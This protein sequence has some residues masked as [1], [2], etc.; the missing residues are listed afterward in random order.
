MDFLQFNR[1]FQVLICTRC[2]YALVPGTIGSHLVSLHKNEVTKSERR[3]CA[4]TWKNKPLQPVQ[5]IQRLDL[6]VDTLPIPN[7]ALFHNGMR[8]RLCTELSYICGGGTITHMQLHLKT[9]HGWQSGYNGGRPSKEVLAS[10]LA[11]L[12]TVIITPVSYQTFHRS[13][14]TRYFQVATLLEPD[15]RAPKAN[16]LPPPATLE[17]QIELQL[18]E[19]MRVV[20]ARASTVLQ[21][22]LE[23]SAWIQTTEWIRYLQGHDIEAAARLI[24]LPHSSE[25]EPDLVAILASFDRL[26]EQARDSVLQGK[27]NAFDQQRI[28]SFLRSGSRTSKA[29]DRPLAHKLKEGTYRKYKNTWKQLLCFVFRMIYLERQPALHCLLT[30]AQSAALDGVAY[31]ARVFVQQQGLELCEYLQEPDMPTRQQK[32]D[33]A[34]LQFCIALLDHR[35]MGDIFDS[36]IVGFLAVLGIDTAR[37]GFQEATAYTPHL[38]ALI[39]ISQLLV[40]QRAVVAAEGGETEYPAQMIEV[41]QDRFMVYGSRSPIDW[42]QKLRVYGKKIRDS[43]TSLGY[44]IWSDDGQKLDYKGL[45]LSM[46]GLKQ[47]VRQQV[48][49]VQDQLQQLLLIH[50]KE[51]KEDVIPMLRLQDLKD[52]PALSRLGQSFL[53]DPRNLGLQDYDRWLLNR[54]LKYG[55][56][57]NE[58]FIDV[59]QAIWRL[60]AV[61]HYI[62]Q[63]DEFLERLLLL[64]HITSGQP[65]RGTELPSLQYCNSAHGRRRNVF[66]ENGL[67]TFVTFCYKGYSITNSTKVIHRYLPQEVSELLVYYL[68]LVLPFCTQLKLLALNSKEPV[69]PYLWAAKELRE[70][71]TSTEAKK[72]ARL[73]HW[74]SSRLSKVLQ[75]E[76]KAYLNTT[77]NI[78]IWRHTAIAISRKHLGGAKFKRDYGSEP[79]PTWVAEQTGHTAYVA[80]NVYARGI[81]EAPGHVA[82]A[83]AEYRALS[84]TWHSFLGFGVYLGVLPPN[85]LKRRQEDSREEVKEH[86]LA[87][88]AMEIVD[89]EAEV[90]RRVKLEL[91]NLDC[92]H[93]VKR[94]KIKQ[95]EQVELGK[96]TID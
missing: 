6:P 31:A 94:Q 13:N 33:S 32:L 1:R 52:D 30:S 9:V 4:E 74:D 48:E 55:W 91:L 3:D 16:R 73:P 85:S 59:K 70:A 82:S 86:N 47:F 76:F 56:L 45:E 11:V 95:A 23:Q 78:T 77:A 24:A 61:E 88:P 19:K 90:Q 65:P 81:E 10:R 67:V 18:A 2:E 80:G 14:F 50:A 54:V 25:P 57:Q 34:C 43:T 89:I 21:P 71:I 51:V 29:S 92:L 44:I 37:E 12:S 7:L 53:T 20:D 87:S 66:I 38:S 58:F 96:E 49:L 68:W 40:L 41:M 17:A 28:N 42:A 64:V 5:A 75:Q 27:V 72:V 39:K 84:R 83:R 63:V 60:R 35:L 15:L 26:I 93:Q 36:A 79:A 62:R 8:C 22:P 46:S 69:S